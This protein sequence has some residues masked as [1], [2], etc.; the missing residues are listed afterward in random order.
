MI[1]HSVLH[2]EY[3]PEQM[4]LY[5]WFAIALGHQRKYPEA[6]EEISECLELYQTFQ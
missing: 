2:F 1:R 3:S 6:I 4:N 5:Y